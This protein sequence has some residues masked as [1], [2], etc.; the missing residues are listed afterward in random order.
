MLWLTQVGPSTTSIC[1]QCFA[2]G[3][4]P[5]VM[6]SHMS[7]HRQYSMFHHSIHHEALNEDFM[8]I[9]SL[10]IMIKSSAVWRVW[11]PAATL[12]FK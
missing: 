10:P 4:A 5:E 12:H 8:T 1:M 3:V 9:E 7:M 11:L 6:A 2:C